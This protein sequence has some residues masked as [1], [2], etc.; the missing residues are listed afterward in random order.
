MATNI[1]KSMKDAQ[2]TL[3]DTD[4]S[5]TLVLTLEDGDFTYTI[6]D[7]HQHV[8]DRGAPGSIIDGAFEPITFSFTVQVKEIT[9]SVSLQDIV[10]GQASGW[11]FSVMDD[12][13]YTS[14][15]LTAG[16]DTIATSAYDVFQMEVQYTDPGDD[17]TETVTFANC[18]GQV[19]FT[20][21]MPNK[22]AV[23]GS[24]YMTA[25]ALQSNI[26]TSA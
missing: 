14:V 4:R 22:I 8:A 6:P 26:A 19:Q 2:I 12:T 16:T 24:C 1:P 3:C 18:T 10:T 17:A 5:N 25:S 9:G 20:E 21:G 15:S 13:G 7:T 11:D 23:S